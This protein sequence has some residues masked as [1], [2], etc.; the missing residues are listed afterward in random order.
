MADDMQKDWAEAREAKAADLAARG[1]YLPEEEH[2]SCGVGLVAAVDGHPRRSVV[3]HA[4]TALK[5]VWHRGA[6]DADGKTG[7]GAGIYTEIPVE[8]FQD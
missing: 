5:A 8:F 2:A 6:V 3:E 7:D 4:I 1:M